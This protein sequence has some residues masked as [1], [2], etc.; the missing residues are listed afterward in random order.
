MHTCFL[1]GTTLVPEDTQDREDTSRKQRERETEHATQHRVT[2]VVTRQAP[3]QPRE[4]M[5]GCA[6]KGLLESRM[7]RDRWYLLNKAKSLKEHTEA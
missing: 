4:V 1:E 7:P 3:P 5:E 2:W 6:A